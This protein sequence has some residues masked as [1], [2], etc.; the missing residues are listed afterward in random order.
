M[1]IWIPDWIKELENICKPYED[2]CHLVEGAPQEVID[3]Y[4]KVNKWY[5]DVQGDWQ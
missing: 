5:E 4:E 1:R 2:G 3:A